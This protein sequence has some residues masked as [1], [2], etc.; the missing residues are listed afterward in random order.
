[1]RPSRSHRQHPHGEPLA[2]VG[3]SA[4]VASARTSNT[5]SKPPPSTMLDVASAL[6][7]V[8]VSVGLA[9]SIGL[10]V[11]VGM[12]VLVGVFVIAGA[13]VVVGVAVLLAFGVAVRVCGAAATYR[14]DERD[15]VATMI[16]NAI[17]AATQASVTRL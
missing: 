17:I 8:T 16:A 4:M 13:A 3:R 7:I 11:S 2:I 6:P 10:G 1:M 12:T 9:V 15:T 5:R 14:V